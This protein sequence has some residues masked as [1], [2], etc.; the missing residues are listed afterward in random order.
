M[1]F[2]PRSVKPLD[3]NN[4]NSEMSIFKRQLQNA[5][6]KKT[7]L[8]TAEQAGLRARVMAHID[9]HPVNASAETTASRTKTQELF[10][11]IHI[12]WLRVRQYGAATAAIVLVMVPLVAESTVP[13]D[14][15]YA[16]KVNVNEELRSTLTFDPYDRIE[17]QAARVNRRIAEV[18]Q[19]EREG[20]LTE[21]IEAEAA[22]AVIEHTE[23]ANQEINT[24]R[25]TDV[26]GAA[27]AAIELD[28]TLSVQAE[29]L[30]TVSAD[31]QAATSSRPLQS[32]VENS[33]S[34]RPTVLTDTDKLIAR[35]EENT[36]RLSILLEE[37]RSDTEIRVYQ[38][39]ERRIYDVERAF[40]RELTT[41]PAERDTETLTA[42]LKRTQTLIVI[43]TDIELRNSV[44]VESFVPLEL[45]EEEQLIERSER[46]ETLVALQAELQEVEVSDAN[47]REKLDAARSILAKAIT[48]LPDIADYAT[49]LTVVNEAQLVGQD[50]LLLIEATE[51]PVAAEPVLPDEED[52]L[53]SATTST[54]TDA[55]MT[56]GEV[57]VEET[58]TSMEEL[59][60][61]TTLAN[62][63]TTSTSTIDSPQ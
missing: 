4:Q 47:V 37:N 27:I 55:I 36:G 5:A 18:K 23:R 24:L 28:T 14:T 26:E 53:T 7:R 58:A 31:G 43:L 3:V 50:A 22:A 20:R 13:G 46:Y 8:S 11:H 49:Y 62:P 25:T 42:L 41:D 54:S 12:S 32:A 21:S 34:V 39:I 33:K 16:V 15:L 29:A 59:N 19:L 35:I 57:G 60:D 63:A 30:T 56:V 48:A 9:F 1:S 38:Q 44:E 6:D 45:T 17:W 10:T 61:E 51:S 40:A 2:L 52:T